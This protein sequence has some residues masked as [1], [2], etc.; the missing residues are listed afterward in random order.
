MSNENEQRLKDL[1]IYMTVCAEGL[2]KEP[3]I[4]GSL[5]LIE[6]ARMLAEIMKDSG[7]DE[8][9]LPELTEVIESGKYKSMTD[10]DA[11]YDMIQAAVLLFVDLQ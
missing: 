10:P 4:Y 8:P 11:F 3:A 2:R 7:C 6:S 5:R 9:V 1:L